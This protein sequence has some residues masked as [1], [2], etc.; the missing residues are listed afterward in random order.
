MIRNIRH[1]VKI[2]QERAVHAVLS[3]DLAEDYVESMGAV[4]DAAM[5]AAI[6]Q[7][8]EMWS[9]SLSYVVQSIKARWKRKMKVSKAISDR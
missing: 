4:K 5:L 1:R 7:S 9:A 6:Q 2:V 8:K 3:Q